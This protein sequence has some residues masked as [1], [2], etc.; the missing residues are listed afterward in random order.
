MHVPFLATAAKWNVYGQ[1]DLPNGAIAD[2]LGTFRATSLF[3]VGDFSKPSPKVELLYGQ[4][5]FPVW[6]PTTTSGPFAHWTLKS[7]AMGL[8]KY[9]LSGFGNPFNNYTWSMQEF[10][11]QLFVGTMDWSYILAQSFPDL[12]A[13]AGVSL[14]NI[15]LPDPSMFF[16]AD[17]W[18][19]KSGNSPATPQS[20]NGVGNFL[21]YGIR[22]MASDSRSLYLGT[23]NPMNLM[24]NGGWE[25]RSAK[26]DDD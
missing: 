2:A 22:T 6:D 18:R 11:N 15:S 17:L 16:G 23:A 21:N 8:P 19:F 3:R 12:L 1:A 26:T 13:N 4:S 25:L 24:A 5:I 14:G 7:G 9:A 20:I 10:N